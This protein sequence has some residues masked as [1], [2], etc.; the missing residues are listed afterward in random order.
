MAI[1]RTLAER[2]V[3]PARLARAI[4]VT[5][6]ASQAEVARELGVHRTTIARWELGSRHPRPRVAAAY[7]ALLRELEGT[8]R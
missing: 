2:S 3:P 5:A 6:G 7:A 8:V 1:S 4:R